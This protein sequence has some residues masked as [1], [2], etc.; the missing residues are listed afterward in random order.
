MGD[1]TFAGFNYKPKP[2]PMHS[3]KQ[4]QSGT[5]KCLGIVRPTFNCNIGKCDICNES[6]SWES[7][8]FSDP[9]IPYA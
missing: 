8:K 5:E 9:I 1:F 7:L 4:D 2:C 6:I 3:V